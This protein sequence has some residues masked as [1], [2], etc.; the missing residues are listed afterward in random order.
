MKVDRVFM[1]IPRVKST[2]HVVAEGGRLVF[3]GED[4]TISVSSERSGVLE[5]IVSSLDG[6]RT[7]HDLV[8]EFPDVHQD[9]LLQIIQQLD[10]SG[11]LEPLQPGQEA[12]ELVGRE[13]ASG[14]LERSLGALKSRKRLPDVRVAILSD[15]TVN[16]LARLLH[17]VGVTATTS[18][19]FQDL[20]N[21][22]ERRV[23]L[24][25]EVVN[26]AVRDGLIDQAIEQ[27][28]LVVVIE[29]SL[30]FWVLEAVNR[31]CLALKRSWLLAS[32]APGEV[33]VGPVFVPGVTC[34]YNCLDSRKMANIETYVEHGAAR[35]PKNFV[36]VADPVYASYVQSTMVGLVVNAVVQHLVDYPSLLAGRQFVV[37]LDDWKSEL[38]DVLK[39]PRCSSCSRLREYCEENPW[40]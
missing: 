27:V 18:V 31:R 25:D 32:L 40:L 39:V 8:T 38:H 7:I 19:N 33:R 5:R 37:R 17:S 21:G 12:E 4:R 13:D 11:I 14:L 6:K 15:G 28:A 1:T 10:S 26:D 30:P 29:R 16:D 35:N 36:K 9:Q 34:C 2:F 24:S 20:F 3:L 22:T 23:Q